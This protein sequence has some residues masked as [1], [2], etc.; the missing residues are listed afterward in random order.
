RWTPSREQALML[1]LAGALCLLAALGWGEL[2]H[3]HLFQSS[4]YWM[5]I[6]ACLLLLAFQAHPPAP[7]R[8]LRWLARMGEMSYELYLSHMF[9]VLA[10]VAIYRAQLGENQAWTFAIYLPVLVL[11]YA[12][13]GALARMT[14]HI[15]RGVR[16]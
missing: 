4:L 12:L 11:C 15:G 8:G 2:V 6:G 13:A 10:A 16:R 1:A 9:V 14:A 3:R 7:R 5:C